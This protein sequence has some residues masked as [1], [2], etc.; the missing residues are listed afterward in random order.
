MRGHFRR[1]DHQLPAM[2]N[3]GLAVYQALIIF[4]TSS[5]MLFW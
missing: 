1:I 3:R 5:Y 4:D 2:R